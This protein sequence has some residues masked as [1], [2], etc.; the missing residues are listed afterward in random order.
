MAGLFISLLYFSLLDL[1]NIS[2]SPN[3]STPPNSILTLK[4]LCSFHKT[5]PSVSWVE[6]PQET[7]I[8]PKCTPFGRYILHIKDLLSIFSPKLLS[9]YGKPFGTCWSKGPRDSQ[10][11]AGFASALHC[12]PEREH[13]NS[14]LMTEHTLDTALWGAEL[15]LTWKFPRGP[16]LIVLESALQADKGETQSTA[17]PGCKACEPQQWPDQEDTSKAQ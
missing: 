10:D 9:W 17:L 7:L 5:K 16:V 12:L 4:L 13:K 15:E 1:P 6:A 2:S 11:D 3:P 8:L 14:L